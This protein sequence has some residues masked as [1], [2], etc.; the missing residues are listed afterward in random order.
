ML[1]Y[2]KGA[3]RAVMDMS[4]FVLLLLSGL[5]CSTSGLWREYHYI[6][7]S[8]TWSEAQSYC[9]ERFTDLATVDSMNDVNRM[10]NKVN[11][12]YSR[13]VWIGLKRWKKGHWLWSMENE[14]L[15]RFSPWNPGEPTGDGECVFYSHK[16]WFDFPCASRLSFVCYNKS[17]GYVR[18]NSYKNWTGA[19]SH[20]RQYH[21]DL[22]TIRSPDE[23][24]QLFSLVEDGSNVWIGLCFDS[25]HWSD[26]W[27]LFRH[28]AVGYTYQTLASGDCVAMS[29]TDSESGKWVHDICDNQHHFFCHGEDKRVGKQIVR[30]NLSHDGKYSLN[31]SS[32]QT[33]ILNEIS[34]RLKSVG[35]EGYKNII[36]R[37]DEGGELF[38]F[39]KRTVNSNKCD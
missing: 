2:Q 21:T 9:R 26:Q 33:D 14:T 7:N 16:L 5:V 25:W 22:A 15:S 29:A 12:G 28:W 31:D 39:S 38:H 35:L 34:E 17:T 23:E 1:K 30:L 4:V 32:L 3:V 10:M 11:D 24:N 27:T 18:V 13:S 37:K 6:N 8:M 19:Q 36:W 20:C